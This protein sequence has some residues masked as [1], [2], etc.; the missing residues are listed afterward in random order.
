MKR[1]VNVHPVGSTRLLLG[2]LPFLLLALLYQHASDARLAE[3]AS[4]RLLPAFTTMASTFLRLATEADV[5]SGLVPLWA[6]T[7]ASLTRLVLGV[8]IAAIAALVTGIALGL[9][10][11]L[12]AQLSPLLSAISLVP[13][14]ALLPILFVAVGLGETAKVTLIVIGIAPYLM[15]DL[16]AHVRALPEEQIVKAQTLSAGTWLLALRVV[17]PQVAPRLIEGIRLALGPAWL[18]L[19]AAEAIASTE[20][21]GYRIFLM[22]RYMAMDAI[23]PYVIWLT[24]IAC[25]ADAGLRVL[26][27]RC[28]PWYFRAE[29]KTS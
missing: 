9:V 25:F 23:V 2:A 11:L 21:L 8:G 7:A 18:F 28:F 27:R 12:R 17:L 14:M 1:L 20:G 13:P 26:N 16:L 29:E 19:I 5:R 4:D 3:N 24:L 6:D 22:R 10:P 15:R